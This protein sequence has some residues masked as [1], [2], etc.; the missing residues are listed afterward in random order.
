MNQI[1]LLVMNSLKLIRDFGTLEISFTC[2]CKVLRLTYID[3]IGQLLVLWIG[4]PKTNV[5]L[6]LEFLISP[7]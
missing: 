3:L 7:T 4:D 1:L 5:S 6:P 2:V